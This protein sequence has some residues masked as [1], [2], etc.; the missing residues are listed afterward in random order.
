MNAKKLGVPIYDKPMPH[1]LWEDL[2]LA[3]GSIDFQKLASYI[4]SVGGSE[5]PDGVTV[6]RINDWFKVAEGLGI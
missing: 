5:I 4:E 6:S 3:L 1:I 2:K